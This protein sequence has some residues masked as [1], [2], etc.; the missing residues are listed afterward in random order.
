MRFL[1][2]G[3]IHGNSN[4]TRIGVEGSGDNQGNADGY[5]GSPL[6]SVGTK[7]GAKH[8]ARGARGGDRSEIKQR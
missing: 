4:M 6:G 7:S 3:V 2:D 1:D 8:M 5:P